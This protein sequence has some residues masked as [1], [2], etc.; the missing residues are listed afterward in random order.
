MTTNEKK[1]EHQVFKIGELIVY[2][3]HGVG[4]IVSVDAQVIAGSRLEFFVI[5]FAKDKMTLRVPTDK[6]VSAGV[7]KLA[8]GAQVTRALETLQG[9]ARTRPRPVH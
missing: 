4:Q 5:N 3:A 7:R 1:T 2:P 8:D 9:R 6:I